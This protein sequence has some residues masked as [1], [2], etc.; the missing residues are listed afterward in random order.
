MQINE[1]KAIG[2]DRMQK[3][4]EYVKKYFEGYGIDIGCGT[5]RVSPDILAIDNFDYRNSNSHTEAEKIK[6]N[7]IVHDCKNLNCKY[8]NFKG[9]LYTF[10]VND[11][12]FIFSSHCLED[13]ENIPVVFINW[14]RKLKPDGY[15]ILLLPDMENGRY[16]K[17]GDPEGNPSHKTDVGLGYIT[18]ML[19]SLKYFQNIDYEIIQ[20]DT[21]PHDE[22]S[23]TVDIVI[24]KRR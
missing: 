4:F 13:F 21:I 18:G 20:A 6:G 17:C 15:M 10:G 5:N 9:H 22:G 8:F 11:L 1:V 2:S 24:K 12:D 14:W 16:P 7:D 3:E 19:D 23:C